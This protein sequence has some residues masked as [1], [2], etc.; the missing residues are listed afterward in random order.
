[1]IENKLQLTVLMVRYLSPEENLK[2]RG[3][4]IAFCLSA[5][6]DSAMYSEFLALILAETGNT[7]HPYGCMVDFEL[8]IW[9]GVK[10]VFPDIMIFGCLFHFKQATRRWMSSKYMSDHLTSEEHA[11]DKDVI[12]EID[13]DLFQLYRQPS[14]EEFN[15]EWRNFQK[16]W[17]KLKD[18]LHYLES[19]YIK[20]SRSSFSIY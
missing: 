14:E 11:M 15:L 13:S 9:E 17:K 1:M 12:D 3:I 10:Q 16:K 4:P 19:T 6:K 18:F 5:V 7:W 8:A 20:H 2:E